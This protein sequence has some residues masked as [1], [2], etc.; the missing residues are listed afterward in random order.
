MAQAQLNQAVNLVRNEQRPRAVVHFVIRS[1][2]PHFA[3][4]ICKLQRFTP[5]RTI[6]QKIAQLAFTDEPRWREVQFR[7]G[8]PSGQVILDEETPDSI[9]LRSGD[10]IYLVPLTY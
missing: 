10:A 4:I 5:F 6:F 7:R 2:L 8:S 1:G 9:S 3:A